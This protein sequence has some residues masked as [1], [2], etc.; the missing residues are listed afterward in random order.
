MSRDYVSKKKK[1][2]VR[3]R[4]N[5]CCEYC[6][7]LENFSPQTFSMEHVI[8]IILGGNNTLSNLALSC[9]TCNNHKYNKIEV[10]DK[11]TQQTIPLF[12]PR[13]D[14]WTEHFKWSDDFKNILSLTNI[15]RVTIKTLDINRPSL[16]N[17]RYA[18]ASAGEHP[19][20]HTLP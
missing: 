14:T 15:G 17:F 16:L 9:Q 8:P 6:Q 12:N 5:F 20:F 11:E 7:S 3:K 19:P 13:K 4:A 18:V 1:G 10:F 2:L